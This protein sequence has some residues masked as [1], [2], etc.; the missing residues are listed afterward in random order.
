M[1]T[2]NEITH[3][4]GFDWAKDHQDVLILDGA[5]KIVAEFR[6]DHAASG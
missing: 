6:F 2:W 1:K 3:F 5:G 4:V